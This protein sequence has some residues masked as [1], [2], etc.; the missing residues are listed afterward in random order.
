MSPT[1][2]ELY[3][4]TNALRTEGVIWA[5]ES[6]TMTS[7]KTKIEELEFSRLEGG[8]FQA[9]VTPHTTLVEKMSGLANQ[10]SQRF[11]EVADTLIHCANTYEAE[12]R[13]GKHNIDNL[14]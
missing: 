8:I 14:W 11:D 1:P 6:D 12:D 4:A 5:R 7:L 9:I 2:Q 3:V 13:A 10:A